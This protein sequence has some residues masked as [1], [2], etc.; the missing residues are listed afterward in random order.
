[1]PEVIQH[2]LEIAATP[3]QV[4]RVLMDF[5]AYARWNPFV[6]QISGEASLGGVLSLSIQSGHHCVMG[7]SPSVIAVE[8][9]RRFS[10][11][12]HL[13]IPGLFDGEHHFEIEAVAE[14]RVCFRQVEYFS[15][16][17]NRLIL[18]FVREQTTSGFK[19]MNVALKKEVE[20]AKIDYTHGI[21]TP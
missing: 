21:T 15:G 12:G 17:L 20:R 3:D 10:W 5:N 11:R 14:N 19:A 4:W 7:F 13:Y 16:L 1:M 18:K 2:E 9:R 8:P 6:R